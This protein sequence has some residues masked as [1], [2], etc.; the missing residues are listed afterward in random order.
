MRRKQKE[1]S[2]RNTNVEVQELKQKISQLCK[3]MKDKNFQ[4][5]I[6]REQ[7]FQIYFFDQKVG[8]FWPTFD[9]FYLFI[10]MFMF[11]T[12]KKRFECST[13]NII[14]TSLFLCFLFN[15]VFFLVFFNVFDTLKLLFKFIFYTK[16]FWSTHSDQL[17][18]VDPVRKNLGQRVFN[19]LFGLSCFC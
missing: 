19:I 12:I 9:Y 1:I 13:S 3:F 6:K 8:P 7:F 2:I 15:D 18:Q 5:K 10:F 11:I 16:N 14:L 4:K 17:S